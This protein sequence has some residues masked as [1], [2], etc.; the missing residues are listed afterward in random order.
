MLQ[1]A[2][3]NKKHGGFVNFAFFRGEDDVKPHRPRFKVDNFIPWWK[4]AVTLVVLRC[5]CRGWK[6]MS[7]PF[8]RLFLHNETLN[9]K[10]FIHT[11]MKKKLSE[12]R[13]TTGR[14][15]LGSI[16][17]STTKGAQHERLLISPCE[18]IK[19]C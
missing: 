14:K 12:M 19:I 17:A 6:T 13:W 10:N 3:Y 1:Q 7:I 5:L 2:H 18:I 4:R 16:L 8:L 11:T 9:R 15:V